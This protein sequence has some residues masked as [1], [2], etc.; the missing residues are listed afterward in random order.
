MVHNAFLFSACECENKNITVIPSK[1]CW[2]VYLM[3]FADKGDEHIYDY[4]QLCIE[5]N[6]IGIGCRGGFD[7]KGNIIS[8]KDAPPQYAVTAID[9]MKINDIVITRLRNGKYYIGKISSDRLFCK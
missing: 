4:Q 1:N 9:E 5:R 3:P 6:L 7:D 8:K 2:I